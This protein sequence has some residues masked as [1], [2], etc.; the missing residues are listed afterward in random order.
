MNISSIYG[1]SNRKFAA[2]FINAYILA[3]HNG[4][5]HNERPSF[6]HFNHKRFAEN[7]F[8]LYVE[9]KEDVENLMQKIQF[10]VSIKGRIQ[11]QT[12]THSVKLWKKEFIPMDYVKLISDGNN[13]VRILSTDHFVPSWLK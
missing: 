6:K 8:P 1:K 4:F 7:D 11:V 9:V 2:S 5:Q 13:T 10:N 12:E 3:L